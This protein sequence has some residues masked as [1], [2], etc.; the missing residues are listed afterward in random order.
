MPY[1]CCPN[2]GTDYLWE[3]EQA[4]YKFGFG[5]GD[6]VV[7]TH[8]VASV[9]R[10]VGYKVEHQFWG[11]HNDVI[12][13]IKKD[14]IELMPNDESEHEVGYVDPRDYLPEEIVKLLDKE[15]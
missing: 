10:A 7:H 1:E 9:L 14:G 15:L 11:M 5:D 3:W 4:F 2:C 13:S 6:G 8:E 12:R